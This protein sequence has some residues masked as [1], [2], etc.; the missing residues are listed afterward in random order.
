MR[1][2]CQTRPVRV[3]GVDL[4][5]AEGSNARA[6]NETGVAA[7]DGAG[8]VLDAGWTV[9]V[10][11]TA[12]W[13]SQWQSDDTLLLVD[14]PL[15][16]T[17]PE[18]Q[19]PCE[20]DVGRYYGRWKVSAN[21]TNLRSRR[22]AGVTL[23]RTL[24]GRGWIYDDGRNGPPATGKVVSECYPYTAIVG[25]SEL[26]FHEE[27]PTYKRKPKALR[28]PEFRPV[29]ANACD[30]LI[31]A[32]AQ[33]E[34]ADPPLRLRS[35][36]VTEQLVSVPS[37]TDDRSYKHREDLI[38]ALI[39]AWTGLLWIRHGLDRCQVLGVDGAQS[40]AATIIAPCRATQRASLP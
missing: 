25:A 1:E 35:H 15:V 36:P 2:S 24:E 17:N 6:A 33:L 22:L 30:T 4:A 26:G 32:L 13:V 9:G 23:R 11:A 29:R 34:T 27:R 16:V 8:H 18:G 38:D 31:A 3:L 28:T 10:A 12:S 14:A 39:C 5:W 20:R 7:V 40:P 19:R 37:P 21:S